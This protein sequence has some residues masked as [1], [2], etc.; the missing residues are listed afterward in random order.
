MMGHA[1]RAE[2]PVAT[3]FW[4]RF[5]PLFGAGL[6]GVAALPLIVM[7]LLEARMKSA[8]PPGMSLRALA[9]LALI[10]PALL[11]ACATA[12]GALVAHRVGF[13]SHLARVN[14][15]R[16][17]RGEWPL[18][19][20]LGLATGI[21]VVAL[22]RLLFH[23]AGTSVALADDVLTG[24]V[25]GML[26]GGLTEEIM[27]RWGLVSLLAWA[28][29]RVLGRRSDG[30]STDGSRKNGP[31]TDGPGTDGPG[32]DGPGTDGP[33][34]DGPGTDGSRT[35]VRSTGKRRATIY[36]AAIVVGAVVFAAGHLPAASALTPLSRTGIAR[37]V[38]LN[39]IPGLVFGWLYW[40]RSLESAMAAHASVHVVFAATRALQW[41]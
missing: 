36:A 11:L 17:L 19:L 5:W 3:S 21:V 31:G 2:V 14:V 38:L 13:S 35:D 18:A 23:S 28:G 24:L 34:T 4:R 22:D 12:I 20:V 25:A 40:R 39:T 30:R 27:M 32:T 8:V 26:Y 7:P 41:A 1:D 10:Q 37:I 15:T 33:G 16:T 9:A 6:A 29:M